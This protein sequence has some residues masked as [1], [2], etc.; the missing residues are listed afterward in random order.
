MSKAISSELAS[1]KAA[2]GTTAAILCR[3]STPGQAAEGDSLEQQEESCRAYA[4]R[5]GLTVV[6]LY[7]AQE[8]SLTLERITQEKAL[9]G[10]EAGLFKMLIVQD[11]SR[12]TSNMLNGLLATKRL[13]EAGVELHA[14]SVGRVDIE[15]PQGQYLFATLT[16]ARGVHLKDHI[17]ASIKRRMG[18]MEREGRPA[19]GRP[20]W[21]RIWNKNR[22]RYEAVADERARLQHAYD[23]IVR[24]GISLNSA[25]ERLKPKMARSSLR[26][27]IRQSALTEIIQHLSGKEYRFKCMPILTA[28]QQRELEATLAANA[29]VRPRTKGK[30]LLQG[31]VR[32]G[33]CSAAMTGQTSTK[34][35]KSYSIYRHPRRPRYKPG[36]TWQVPVADLDGHVLYDCAALVGDS[37]STR[38]AVEQALEHRDTGAADLRERQAFKEA[39]IKRINARVERTLDLL[40][41]FDGKP[42]TLKRL[43]E[44]VNRDE[45]ELATLEGERDELSRQ[46]TFLELSREQADAAVVKVRSL[47]WGYGAGTKVLRFDQQRDF[48]RTV[49]QRDNRDATEGVYV[50]MLRPHKDSKKGIRWKYRIQGVLLVHHAVLNAEENEA[51]EMV[52]PA[53]PEQIKRLARIAGGSPGIKLPPRP[54]PVQLRMKSSSGG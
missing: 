35:R 38:A 20:P 30:Y 34:D 24:Q 26:K 14:V 22:E 52:R 9:A 13:N 51:P 19:A 17:N 15:T 21:G 6:K 16:G 46:A 8:S 11:V 31:L 7:S 10:A 23:L 4:G 39:E 54:Y 53:T 32:C 36:C 28:K 25:A 42:E 3:V 27:A 29:T 37:K 41:E 18:I 40:R 47:Y 33:I 44:R 1:R 12:F 48:V 50:T 45:Q 5:L 2:T 49:I 43:K